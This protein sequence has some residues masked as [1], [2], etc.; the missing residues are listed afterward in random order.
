MSQEIV[1]TMVRAADLLT[2]QADQCDAIMALL[3]ASQERERVNLTTIRE[4]LVTVRTQE[5]E[6]RELNARIRS[7]ERGTNGQV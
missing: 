3:E 4:L 7:H 1:A 2:T 6:I 5:A